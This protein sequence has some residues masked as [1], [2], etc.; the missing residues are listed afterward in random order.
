MAKDRVIFLVDEEWGEEVFCVFL[1]TNRRI[2]DTQLGIVSLYDIY[3]HIG[4]HSTANNS[5]L[6][7]DR[8]READPNEFSELLEEITQI[9]YKPQ[10]IQI[11][12]KL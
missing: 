1:D 9:G 3:A 7:E 10:V 4:Q 5:Y 11:K 8:I 2:N 6:N 12:S